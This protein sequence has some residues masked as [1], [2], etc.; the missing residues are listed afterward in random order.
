M[1]TE[2]AQGASAGAAPE[3]QGQTA[4][5][6]PQT[7]G[8][9]H[10]QTE[11]EQSSDQSS[12]EGGGDKLTPEQRTIK[13]LERRI[14]RLTAKTSGHAREAEMYRQQMAELQ[15]RSQQGFDEPQE[16]APEKGAD[17]DS[18]VEERLK[19]QSIASTVEK[20][21]ELGVSIEDF[22]EATEAVNGFLP[23]AR[24]VN[25]RKVPTPFSEA[26]LS[27]KTASPEAAAKL[28]KYLG[29]NL[30]EAQKLARLSPTE[31]GWRLGELHVRLGQSA[32]KQTSSAPKP[33]QPIKAGNAG[34]STPRT[35]EE[36]L[37]ELRA[38][39]SK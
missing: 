1:S 2:L 35:P 11:T 5:P 18:L 28:L 9:A 12:D 10:Q 34:I 32:T 15:Q 8:D 25:G 30:G 6:E 26:L 33:L 21:L 14:D 23:F 29:D 39:R 22:T 37:N 31:L 19:Q 20:V 17:I 36:L 3:S 24:V 4:Q 27:G 38:M 13:K 16:R 7:A